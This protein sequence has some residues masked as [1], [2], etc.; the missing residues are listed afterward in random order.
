MTWNMLLINTQTN[1][2]SEE[3]QGQVTSAVDVLVDLRVIRILSIHHLL[4]GL[5]KLVHKAIAVPFHHD[6]LQKK[7]ETAK[8]VKTNLLINTLVQSK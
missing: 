1:F 4:H 2:F 3:A 8:G 6:R 7:P 5:K